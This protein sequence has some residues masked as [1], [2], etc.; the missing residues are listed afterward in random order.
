MEIYTHEHDARNMH[1]FKYIIYSI[2]SKNI[3]KMLKFSTHSGKWV[4]THLISI[5]LNHRA[6]MPFL[7]LGAGIKEANAG[8]SHDCLLQ[9]LML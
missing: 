5:H 6:L 8:I 9:L 7:E 1:S 3:S 4:K 2:C